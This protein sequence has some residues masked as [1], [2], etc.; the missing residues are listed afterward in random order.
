MSNHQERYGRKGRDKASLLPELPIIGQRIIDT[1]A[2]GMLPVHSLKNFQLIYIEKGEM[3]VWVDG[4][5]YTVHEK[6]FIIVK[7]Y[8]P[9]AYL[10]GLLP[11]GTQNF[12]QIESFGG[13]ERT[14]VQK[15]LES[16]T[17]KMKNCETKT[18]FA[19]DEFEKPFNEILKEHR[20]QTE[21]STNLAKNYFEILCVNIIRM[22][23]KV[24]KAQKNN[25]KDA[26]FLD[27]MDKYIAK[28]IA[29]NISVHEL[30][31]HSGYS[32]NHFRVLFKK[33]SGTSPLNYLSTKKMDMARELLT[34]GQKPIAEIAYSLGF[35]SSQYF[36]T[37][38]KKQTSFTPEEF[39]KEVTSL[40]NL[41]VP[42]VVTATEAAAQLDTFFK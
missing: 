12:I 36:S 15:L 25:D 41:K 8:E 38:F 11:K 19:A 35:T 17:D 24:N 10:S 3:Q 29:E 1:P 26:F 16:L 21:W 23:D 20:N 6:N 2:R 39:R 27:A 33:M 30:A 28:N 40:L 18:F 5:F 37:F 13:S 31:T 22:I 34:E 14:G 7:P 9:M 32:E 4:R 42:K